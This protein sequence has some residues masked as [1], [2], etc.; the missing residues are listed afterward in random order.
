[1]IKEVI[2]VEGRDDEAA[3]KNA[4]EAE[5][6]ATH[7][8]GIRKDTMT[9]IENAYR[10]NGI[11]IFTDPDHAGEKIRKRLTEQF[12]EAKQA[13]LTRAEAE[14]NGDIGIENASPEDIRLALSKARSIVVEKRNEFTQEDMIQYGLTGDVGA[15]ERRSTLGSMLGIGYGNSKVFL[16]RLNHYG[17]TRREFIQIWINYTRRQASDK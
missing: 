9:L 13:H 10:Q 15:A 8:Y 4:V 14:K 16:N 17:V 5:L 7:G 12:P 2:V 3:V 1:M 6:I 11:I